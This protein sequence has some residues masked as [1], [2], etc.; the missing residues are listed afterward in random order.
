MQHAIRLLVILG[1]CGEA[2][3][4]GD[5]AGAVKVVRSEM[6]LQAL[7]FWLRNPDYLA[8]ELVT[9]VEAGELAT[10]YL[11][12]AD[13]LLKSPEPDLRWYP[14]PRWHF[15]AYEAIDD[16]FAVLDAYGLALVSR[17]GGVVKTARSQFFLTTKGQT[18]VNDLAHEPHL[19]WYTEQVKLVALAAGT[20]SGSV[21]KQRQ[22][23][24]AE[25][26]RTKLGTIIAPIANGVAAR[27]RTLRTGVGPD[28][29]GS[30][31]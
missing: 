17:L 27:L 12:T 1:S 18:A 8:G 7:D 26:A 19:S 25:Y 20:D 30:E 15:G 22:Y 2:V 11:D 29:G 16:A 28:N 31:E 10:S 5:P 14:M 9:K 3:A 24:Q 13:H 21:L 23:R 6:R 4:P